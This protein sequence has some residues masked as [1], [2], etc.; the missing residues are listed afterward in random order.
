[1]SKRTFAWFLPLLAAAGWLLAEQLTAHAPAG[2]LLHDH[3][4]FFTYFSLR[5]WLD[6]MRMLF[7]Q[8]YAEYPV[9]ALTYL[10]WPRLVVDSITSFTWLLQVSNLV[11]YAAAAWFT[12][13]LGRRLPGTAGAAWF[14]WLLPSALYFSLNRFDI[15]PAALVIA[16]VWCLM[17]GHGRSGWLCYGLAVAIKLYPLFIFPLFVSLAREYGQ[18]RWWHNLPYAAAGILGPA[19]GGVWTGGWLAVATPY[20]IQ[21][22][23]NT[24][25]GS[26]LWLFGG[27]GQPSLV[28]PT[29]V[30]VALKLGQLVV[31]LWWLV[32][33]IVRHRQNLR[34]QAVLACLT[35]LVLLLL[36]PFY[37]NQWWLWVLP[38][39][40]L[41][42]PA[43][44]VW[45]A[46]AYDVVNYV[47]FPVVFYSLGWWNWTFILVVVV[48][49]I[50]LLLLMVPLARA[51]PRGWWR[52][53]PGTTNAV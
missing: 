46:A 43:R 34:T 36:N 50:L 39:A 28:H 26:T 22:I 20:T 4:D 47:Q 48:R 30:Y 44:W 27:L 13:D 9:L 17:R 14:L 10:T 52:L 49:S 53:K 41:A 25:W 24:F 15:L 5:G 3:G 18:G 11:L 42:L 33:L 35:L 29:L 19:L 37:S 32:H 6:P 40:A 12:W 51:L 16:G 7:E 21:A 8:N 23:R 2:W 45:L 31:P 1:M 38:F